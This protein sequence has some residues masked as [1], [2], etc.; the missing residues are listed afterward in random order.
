MTDMSQQ[1]KFDTET[2][3]QPDQKRIYND[4]SALI[5]SD[6][7]RLKLATAMKNVALQD[8]G[9]I[10]LEKVEHTHFWR[11]Y[12]SDG[13]KL[14][15]SVPVA[16]HFHEI[17]YEETNG[18]VKVISCSPPLRMGTQ[19]VKG[20]TKM[21]PVPINPDLEDN[22]THDVEYLRSHKVQPRIVNAA[23]QQMIGEVAVK[24]SGIQGIQG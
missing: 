2:T 3:N 8:S 4:S 20:V 9:M 14:N 21:V 12:D 18:V 10:D 13:K 1:K 7:F 11:T 17:K 22:H 6:L 15:F 5:E 23:A 16:G 19:K 24:N